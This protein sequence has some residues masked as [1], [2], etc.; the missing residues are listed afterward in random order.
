MTKEYALTL[1]KTMT[2]K[3]ERC[4]KLSNN[5]VYHFINRLPQLIVKPNKLSVHRAKSI[6]QTK[7]KRFFEEFSIIVVTNNFSDKPDQFLNIDKTG[8]TSDRDH[9][10]NCLQ[11][12]HQ[13]RTGYGITKVISNNHHCCRKCCCY[14]YYSIF[15][16]LALN[17]C[18]PSGAL[19]GMIESGWSISAVFENYLTNHFA[20]HVG[21]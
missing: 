11:Q 3:L 2:T 9:V 6:S 19:R 8:K 5:W 1:K 15:T 4:N 17:A 21:T 7:I 16:R 20:C 10:H 13:Q 14:S 18:F 12:R